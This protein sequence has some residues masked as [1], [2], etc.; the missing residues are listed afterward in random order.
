M[1]AQHERPLSTQREGVFQI[2]IADE[3]SIGYFR[4]TERVEYKD[5]QN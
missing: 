3:G 2:D 1:S 4:L 5:E